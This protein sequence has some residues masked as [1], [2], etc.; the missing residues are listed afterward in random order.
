MR[1]LKNPSFLIAFSK[2]SKKSIYYFLILLMSITGLISC[3]NENDDNPE[4][5][6]EEQVSS[7]P[8]FMD[9]PF[10]TINVVN[11]KMNVQTF[12]DKF[13]VDGDILMSKKRIEEFMTDSETTDDIQS[14][15]GYDF[16]RGRPWY[17][18][19]VYY[20]FDGNFSSYGRQV[21]SQ[22]M[23]IIS[24]QTRVRFQY[25]TGNGNYIRVFTGQGNYSQLGMVGGRQDLSLQN[26]TIGIA[27]HELGH[28]LGLIHEHQRPD[29]DNYIYVDRNAQ[30]QNYYNFVKMGYAY[31]AFD[32]SSI[33]LYPSRRFPNSIGWDMVRRDNGQPFNSNVETGANRLSYGDTRLLNAIYR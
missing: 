33:M 15:A 26:M 27:I 32:F 13:L 11:K 16:S 10:K 18:N 5:L 28:A 4:V 1:V 24:N 21:M 7:N 17:G 25:G 19:T 14:R 23:Q 22:A 3:Q 31:G 6:A 30:M 12:D 2:Q 29:R 8:F 9:I 20:V